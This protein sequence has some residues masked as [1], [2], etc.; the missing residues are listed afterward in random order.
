MESSVDVRL[1]RFCCDDLRHLILPSGERNGLVWSLLYWSG[2]AQ[3]SF[4]HLPMTNMVHTGV[5]VFCLAVIHVLME[6]NKMLPS[7]I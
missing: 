2:L 3:P 7:R 4:T 1:S 5:K 6:G